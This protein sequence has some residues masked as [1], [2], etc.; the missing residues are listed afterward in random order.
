M[1]QMSVD[2]EVD[3]TCPLGKTTAVRALG[4]EFLDFTPSI[5]WLKALASFPSRAFAIEC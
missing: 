4:A 5:S 2:Q 3:L 1:A